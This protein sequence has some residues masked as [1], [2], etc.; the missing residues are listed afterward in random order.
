MIFILAFDFLSLESIFL[1]DT[2]VVFC[3]FCSANYR[4]D[5]VHSLLGNLRVMPAKSQYFFLTFF[6]MDY[7][8]KFSYGI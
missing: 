7:S 3:L 2:K 6:I 8:H 5:H 4:S 1:R